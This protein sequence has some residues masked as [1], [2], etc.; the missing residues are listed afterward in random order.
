MPYEIPASEIAAL[1]ALK[2]MSDESVK[3]FVAAIN[4]VPPSAD[5]DEM[6]RRVAKKVPAIPA[7]KLEAVLDALY[8]IYY[9]REL[10]GVP[11]PTFLND[12]MEGIQNTSELR[13]AK[14]EVP[15]L[16]AKFEGLLNID[17]FNSLSKAKRLQ[18][19]GERL[20]CDAK[21]ISDIRPVFRAEPTE[22]PLG[23]VVTHTLKLGF[24]EGGNHKEFHVILDAVDLD[25]LADVVSRAQEK[26]STLRDLLKSAK[27]A[28]MGV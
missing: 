26:D 23:A 25:M 9:I 20:Y 27:L 5:T 21:I 14:T 10:S 15:K 24:H 12:F 13:V 16:R 7:K 22:R 17:T 1:T 3:A 4:S 2:D 19:D 11:R 6:A 28:D 8:G 18:R